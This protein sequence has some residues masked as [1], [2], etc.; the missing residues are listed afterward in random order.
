MG[1]LEGGANSGHLNFPTAAQGPLLQ[2][3]LL[4][5]SQWA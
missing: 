3:G 2:E 1:G 5:W 4:S